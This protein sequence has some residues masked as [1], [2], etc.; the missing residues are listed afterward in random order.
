MSI[1]IDSL[2]I[3]EAKEIVRLFQQCDLGSRHSRANLIDFFAMDETVIIRTYSAGVWFGVLNQKSGAEVILKNARRLWQ[4][5]CKKS[6]SLS[7][8]AVHGIDQEKSIIAPAVPRVWLEAIEI[9]PIDGEAAKS[10]QEAPDAE[11]R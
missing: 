9:I 4:W 2:T 3:G 7:G 1:N 8:V 10:I 5:R 6:I 11:A